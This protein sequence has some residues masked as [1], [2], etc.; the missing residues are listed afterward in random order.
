MLGSCLLLSAV[1]ILL[2]F[3]ENSAVMEPVVPPST[4][5]LFLGSG[6]DEIVVLAMESQ[7]LFS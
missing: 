2:L 5:A 7:K 4:P 3:K 6:E 1:E